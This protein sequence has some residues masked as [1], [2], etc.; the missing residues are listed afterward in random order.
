MLFQEIYVSYY[1]GGENNV[2]QLINSTNG[3]EFLELFS[4]SNAWYHSTQLF[5]DEI[6]MFLPQYKKGDL[7][8]PNKESCEFT[9]PLNCLEC[10]SEQLAEL[11][12]YLQYEKIEQIRKK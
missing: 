2:L 6:K 1:L 4:K 7:I 11:I 12:G 5:D 3:E 10:Y 8:L 9:N